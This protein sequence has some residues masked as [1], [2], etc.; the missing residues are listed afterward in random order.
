MSEKNDRKDDFDA[1]MTS[2]QTVETDAG[3]VDYRTVS[4]AIKAAE[5]SQRVKSGRVGAQRVKITGSFYREQ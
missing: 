1:F 2:P 3:K 4:D 5:Y